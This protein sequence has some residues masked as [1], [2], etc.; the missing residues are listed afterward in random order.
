MKTEELI[1]LLAEDRTRPGM[2]VGTRAVTWAGLGAVLS[3]AVLI[4]MLG[5]RPDIGTAATGWRFPLKALFILVL[6]LGSAAA[7]MRASQPL[8]GGDRATGIILIA[9]TIIV[10]G[11]VGEL[12]VSQIEQLASGAMGKNPA[13]CLIAIPGLAM[14]PLFGLLAAMR[15]GA[16]VSTSMAGAYAGLM[17]GSL[18]AAIYMIRRTDDSPLFVSLWYV[19]AIAAVT[20]IGALLGHR[21]LRW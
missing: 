18:G 3:M 6:M 21:A 9:F 15:H 19:A 8:P 17:S 5:V 10:A 1:R 16:P 12:L 14:A 4:G 7:Y 11:V 13:P 2:S 20:L